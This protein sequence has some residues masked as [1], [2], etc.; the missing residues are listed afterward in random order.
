LT[1]LSSRYARNVNIVRV[2]I[3]INPLQQNKSSPDFTT[4]I[5]SEYDS[6][7]RLFFTK[8]D[9]E[10]SI[11]GC[12]PEGPDGIIGNI[13]MSVWRI[14]LPVSGEYHVDKLRDVDINVQSRTN[15]KFYNQEEYQVCLF[16]SKDSGNNIC[17]TIDL[18]TFRV[19]ETNLDAGDYV[20]I[21]PTKI[22]SLVYG[23]PTG[24]ASI[25]TFLMIDS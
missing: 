2:D 23:G 5:Q 7:L 1:V 11:S 4:S 10:F 6:S 13:G 25:Q 22:V 15:T 12:T 20:L 21:S 18:K 17:R 19:F 14:S 9:E 16:R 8:L 3:Y 24:F